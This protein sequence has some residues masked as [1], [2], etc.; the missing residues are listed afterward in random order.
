MLGAWIDCKDA[1]TNTTPN[2]EEENE[3]ANTAEIERAVEMANQFPEI[4]KVISVGNEAM[5]RWATSYYVKP[6]IIL[7][8]VT[9]LQQLKKERKLSKNVWITSSDNFASWGG[10]DTSYHTE[11]LKKLYEAVDFVSIHTYPMHD[12]HYNPIFWGLKTEDSYLPITVKADS[13]MVRSVRYAQ[14]QYLSVRNYM[15]SIGVDKPIHIGETGW[16]TADNH[17]YGTAGSSACDEYK[18]AKYYQLIRAWTNQAHITCFYFEAFDEQWKDV[19]NAGGSENHFGLFTIDGKAKYALWEQVDKG[20]FN[21]LSRDGNLIIK[22][23][24]GN[25]EDLMKRVLLPKPITTKQP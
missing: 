12:T 22:T 24:N 14:M 17:L 21:G 2:H 23:M 4:V 18:S 8:W 19:Q 10:G 3:Q 11:D 20:A 6:A 15:Q 1:W 9:Y 7:K 16:A 25:Q 5:V 13:L